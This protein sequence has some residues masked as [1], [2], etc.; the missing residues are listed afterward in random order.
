MEGG[1]V[2][3]R[4]FAEIFRLWAPIVVSLCAIS[5]T[6]FQANATRRHNRLAVQPHVD[7]RLTIDGDT[8]EVEMRMTNV[9]IGPAVINDVVLVEGGLRFDRNDFA[10]CST[11]DERL[12]RTGADW[13]TECFL[14]NEEY[15]LRPGDAVLLYASRRAEGATAPVPPLPEDLDRLEIDVGFCSF[16]E[17]CWRSSDS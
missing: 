15:V 4:L 6:I 5:L 13:D 17:E 3:W 10:V 16:Y 8:G 7:V 12:G 1:G 14:M 11:L 2:R 9:G